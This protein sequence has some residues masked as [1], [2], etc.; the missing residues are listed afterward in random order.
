MILATSESKQRGQQNLLF[1]VLP[2][3][4]PL[5][6]SLSGLP[7]SRALR[8][9]SLSVVGNIWYE[10]IYNQAQV[11]YLLGESIIGKPLEAIVVS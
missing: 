8:L 1:Q 2:T 11:F 3:R 9:H 5:C 10:N 4:V 7:V 6:H